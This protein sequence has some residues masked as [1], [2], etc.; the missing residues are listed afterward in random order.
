MKSRF[1]GGESWETPKL[2]DRYSG[3]REKR[4]GME[5][6]NAA[7]ISASVERSSCWKQEF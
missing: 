7:D 6:W 5:P 4:R 2:W 3:F 1:S